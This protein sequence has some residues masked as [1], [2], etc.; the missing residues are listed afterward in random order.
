[1]RL[2]GRRAA[3]HNLAY[4]LFI[5]EQRMSPVHSNNPRPIRLAKKTAATDST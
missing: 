5:Q 4:R 3:A 1:M 2:A